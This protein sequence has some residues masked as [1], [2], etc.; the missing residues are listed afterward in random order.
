MTIDKN[1]SS[2][3][4]W[5]L[6]AVTCLGPLTMDIYLP[7]FP[8]VMTGLH[9]NATMVQFTLTA[10]LLGFS[11][12]QVFAGTVSDV[13]GRRKP[14]V[15]S[16]VIFALSTVACSLATD[17]YLLIIFR[18]IGG[19]A[20]SAASVVCRAV[21]ADV[22]QGA[23]LT[24]IL[25]TIMIIQ[26]IAPVVAPIIGATLL[27]AFPWEAIFVFLS[28]VIT[29]VILLIFF[30]YRETLAEE[31]RVKGD[32]KNI[33]HIFYLLST[34][35]EFVT[36]CFLQFMVYSSL[37]AYLSGMPFILQGIY[38]FTPQKFSWFFA[39]VGIG[40]MIF[41]KITNLM[42]S[43]VKEK[44]MLLGALCQGVAF[45]LLFFLG[46]YLDWN[47]FLTLF[48]LFLSQVS[49]PMISATS[50]SLALAKQGQ[51]AGSASALLGFYANIAGAMV[52]PLVSIAGE[53]TAMP[54][55][56]IIFTVEVAALLLYFYYRRI[57]KG[58]NHE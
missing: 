57:S 17:I 36:L 37:F 12:G 31:K 58:V 51:Y 41:G 4:I 48:F 8:S 23:L 38:G 30:N 28:I 16:L 33:L 21:A 18:F 39:I 52:A 25:S 10:W 44:T 19:L 9:T 13:I 2:L 11:L 22:Y 40:M 5:L 6:A 32:F 53:K 15:W 34:H 3:L 24:K 35:K 29:L 47:V 20:A 43:F 54:T 7:A 1:K 26:G 27:I 45:A 42:V 46:V 56:V 14:L 49:L 55:A 50:F